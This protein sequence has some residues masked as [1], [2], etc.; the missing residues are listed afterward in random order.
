MRLLQG[1]GVLEFYIAV[2]SSRP[3]GVN[4]QQMREQLKERGPDNTESRVAAW[5]PIEDLKQWYD[6]P[7]ELQSLLANP[8]T[9]FST[10]RQLVAAERNGQFYLLLYTTDQE[11]MT[12]QGDKQWSILSAGPASDQLGR[13]AVSFR[14]DQSGAGLMGRL[15]GA[16]TK[17]PMAIVLDGAV[18]SAPNI[19]SQITSSGII[20]GS[21]SQSEINYLTRVLAAGSLEAALSDRPI[22]I[23][24][25]GPSL[26]ADNLTRGAWAFIAA[27]IAVGI[28][29]I[30]YY[31]FCGLVA[32][33]ALIC[34][35]LIIFGVMSMIDATF[36]LP[37]LAGI[38]LTI[39]MAVDANVLIYERI[40]E[41]LR[42]NDNDLRAAIREGYRK[43]FSTIIDGN[44]TNLIVCLVL[45]K[46]AT[47]EVQGFATTLSIGICATLFTALFVTRVIFTLYAF[48]LG[49]RTLRMLPMVVPALSRALHPN[50]NWVRLR[51]VFWTASVCAGVVSVVLIV[52]RGAELF[53][54]EFRGGVTLTMRTRL[55]TLD[56]DA[57]SDRL[58]MLH[59]GPD[60]VNQRVKSLGDTDPA[61]Q[62]QAI[63]EAKAA[64]AQAQEKASQATEEQAK[65]EA[66]QM[67][68]EAQAKLDAAEAEQTRQRILLQMRNAKVLTVGQTTSGPQGVE[69]DSFQVKVA[70]PPQI[71]NEKDITNAIKNALVKEFASELDISPSLSFRDQN[72]R[73]RA[74]GA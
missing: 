26:G 70:N 53:D 36:T 19:N 46:T 31:F 5:F 18:Y 49:I 24:I 23:N 33:A 56:G 51:G 71:S 50:V 67:V 73:C 45:W 6:K 38:V 35:G 48:A 25:L 62:D 54:T 32:D 9:Y 22:S 69:A 16:H 65:A 21:F 72:Y 8:E 11:S 1:A 30:L 63:S 37:G 7:S 74:S 15:T 61:S 13:P 58:L 44:I 42:E 10:T 14:L 52:S 3:E 40:R 20:Q 4:I 28:F 41:E 2:M 39:G 12:H 60:S 64:L 68:S 47:A 29:M 57:S 27:L 17:E 34:N 55:A 43:A 59:V 66:D